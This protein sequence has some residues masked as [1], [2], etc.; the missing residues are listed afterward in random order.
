MRTMERNID[1]VGIDIDLIR[2]TID[3]LTQTPNIHTW[4]TKIDV[5]RITGK[6]DENTLFLRSQID[7]ILKIHSRFVE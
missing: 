7:K 2:I 1:L 5:K 3:W 4:N 6:V